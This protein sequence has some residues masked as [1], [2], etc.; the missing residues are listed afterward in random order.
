M[1]F[2]IMWGGGLVY[3][4]GMCAFFIVPIATSTKNAY[5]IDVLEENAED[6]AE[7]EQEKQYRNFG[8]VIR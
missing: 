1:R 3:R 2:A 7:Q 4:L 6:Q 5:W 8:N